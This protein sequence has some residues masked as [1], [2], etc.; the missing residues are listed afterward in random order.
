M[1]FR[2]NQITISVL[3]L[4]TLLSKPVI[5]D[6][7]KTPP[8]INYI[9]AESVYLNAGKHAGLAVGT[10]VEVIRLG[11]IIAVLE[12]VHVSSNSAS[13]RVV[14]QTSSPRVGDAVTFEPSE[15]LPALIPEQP[16]PGGFLAATTATGS[17]TNV[18]SGFVSIGTVWQKDL[19]D[20]GLSSLQPALAARLR[21]KNI[22]GSGT[23]FRFRDRIRYYY[24]EQSPGD[25]IAR[26]EWTHRLTEI[27]IV[28]GDNRADLQWG[29][30][31]MIVPDMRGVGLVDGAYVSY[32]LGRW[33]RAGLAGGLSPQPRDLSPDTDRP[34]A[35]GFFA[36]D[37][38][39]EKQ[40]S[41]SSSAAL[42][43]NYVSGSISREFIYWQN[44]F[45]MHRKFSVFQSVEA[46]LN[47]DWRRDAA[48]EGVTF[49]NFY[50]LANAEITR[51]ASVDFTY[52]SR[53]NVR[54]WDT[55]ATPDS[56]FDTSVYDG[57]GGGL[58]LHL[59]RGFNLA[60]RAGVRYR[61]DEQTNR[62]YSARLSAVRLPWR[63]HSTTFR[64]A[65]TDTRF[66][67]AHRPV[68]SYRFPV[69]RLLRLNL[70]GGGY[71]YNRATITSDTYYGEAGAGYSSGHYFING[72][73]RQY[74]G[75]NLDSILIYT[76]L[77]LNL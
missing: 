44:V 61:E 57:F 76:E 66:T 50:L 4:A 12:V 40:W 33:F 53:K 23:E 38:E 42:A 45:L 52:D 5:A 46:D 21:V 1:I 64:Y 27:A 16:L 22:G 13:C 41:F 26:D 62:F 72:S 35:G 51:Y 39:P 37:Y 48:G 36:F 56:L 20:S 43:G 2:L 63:G 9:S 17:E 31:R 67:T 69:G 7:E 11:K 25:N 47:R 73:Y 30:G 18:L 19:T 65:Y 60:G 29:F 58:S 49:T 28:N 75:G 3:L 34:Q 70:G 68:L 32:R 77:G 59:P 55:Q 54:T 71:I 10:R 24:R 8:A 15:N 14:E 6:D 74:F